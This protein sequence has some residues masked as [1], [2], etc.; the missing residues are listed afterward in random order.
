M[1]TKKVS[2]GQYTVP[3]YSYQYI[4]VSFNASNQTANLRE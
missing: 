2:E 4:L 3:G 1:W